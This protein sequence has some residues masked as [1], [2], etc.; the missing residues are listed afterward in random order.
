MPLDK[1]LGVIDLVEGRAVRAVAGR[2]HTYR[3]YPSEGLRSPDPLRLA[4]QYRRLGVGGLYVADLDAISGRPLQAAVLGELLAGDL[5]LWLD[6]G[7]RDPGDWRD[8]QSQLGAAPARWILA[9]ETLPADQRPEAFFEADRTAP[10]SAAT[11]PELTLGLDLNRGV[12][13]SGGVVER[14]ESSAPLEPAL[15]LIAR[16]IAA[17]VRSVLPLDISAVGTR[18]GP[19]GAALCRRIRQQFPDVQLISGGGVRD[20]GD[21]RTLL[22]AGCDAVLAATALLDGRIG[23]AS[24]EEPAQLY[25]DA[26]PNS[27]KLTDRK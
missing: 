9:T 13:R 26:P 15:E 10:S 2:R 6:A 3:P 21:V 18:R 20:A 17:G 19:V 4:Q 7:I 12:V 8:K 22:A 5:P 25:K 11:A 16:W 14:P 27:K 24:S 1:V 23:A